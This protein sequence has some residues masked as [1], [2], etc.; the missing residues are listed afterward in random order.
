MT[1]DFSTVGLNATDRTIRTDRLTDVL[2]MKHEQVIDGDPVSFIDQIS[3]S[4]FGLLRCFCFHPTDT[5]ADPMHVCIYWNR[6]LTKSVNEHAGCSFA[7]N[8]RKRKQSIHIVRNQAAEPLHQNSGYLNDSSGFRLIE[9][10]LL[11]DPL[12]LA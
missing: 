1:D 11:D 4:G 10:C 3:Q 6:R 8:A 2:S 12:Y 9:S 5:V 7:S